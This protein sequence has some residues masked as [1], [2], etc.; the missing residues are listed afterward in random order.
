MATQAILACI[1]YW[2]QV[3]PSKEVSSLAEFDT[4]LAQLKSIEPLI[5]VRNFLISQLGK[6]LKSLHQ[7]VSERAML[8]L[9]SPILLCLVLYDKHACLE[10][11]IDALM[12]N[13]HHKDVTFL[14]LL[15]DTGEYT[16]HLTPSSKLKEE[17]RGVHWNK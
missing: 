1:K 9:Q 14:R 16:Q 10:P 12:E 4:I 7:F 11:L 6:C 8:C 5:P 13:T 3:D 17:M 2:P 15:E